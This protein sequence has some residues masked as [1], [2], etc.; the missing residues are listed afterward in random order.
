M[1]KIKVTFLMLLCILTSRGQDDSLLQANHFSAG[2][3][4]IQ[5]NISTWLLGVPSLGISY[6]PSDRLEV[7]LDGAFSHWKYTKNGLPYYWRNWNI[8][9]QV[10]TYINADKSTY[11]GLQYSMGQSI[12][13]RQLS[14]YKG[15]GITI[16]KQYYAG[17]K[18]LID[19]GISFGYLKLTDRFSYTYSNNVYYKN[20]SKEDLNYWGPTALS[21]RLSRK[22]N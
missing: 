20:R 7:M 15:G 19:L 12:L 17:K 11:L 6:K 18:L 1:L 3:I 13:S 8:S 2:S 21:I 22:V 9:P 16:G 4:S 14:K 5:T 10:R